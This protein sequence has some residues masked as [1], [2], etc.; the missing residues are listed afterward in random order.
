MRIYSGPAMPAE[1]FDEERRAWIAARAGIWMF[2]KRRAELLGKRIRARSRAKVGARPD[3]HDDQVTPPLIFRTSSTT[4]GAL[5]TGVVAVLAA[6]APIGWPAGRML[7][8]LIIGLIPERLQAYPIAALL[9]AAIISGAP[10]P[11]LYDPNPSL[12]STLFIP[13]LLAQIPATFAAAAAYGVL[14]GWLAI[15]GSSD[16]WP[17]TP[18][19]RD[20]DDT[21]ILGPAPVSMPTLLDP[22]PSKG[23]RSSDALPVPRRRPAPVN[24]TRLVIPASLTGAGTCWYLVAVAGALMTVPGELLSG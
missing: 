3:P 1:V 19:Q 16:W 24:W 7:Y 4:T 10:L 17:L 22:A 13:W 9:W 2:Q 6:A 21:L 15:D 18:A 23:N 8:S 12:T 20:V 11:L 14:E 5:E